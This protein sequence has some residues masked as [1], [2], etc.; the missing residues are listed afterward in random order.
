[1]KDNSQH[2]RHSYLIRLDSERFLKLKKMA[3]D[4]PMSDVVN[5]G[6]DTEWIFY[7]QME[8]LSDKIPNF[9]NID[10]IQDWRMNSF[11]DSPELL[12]KYVLPSTILR[13]MEELSSDRKS[14]QE[15][16]DSL[17]TIQYFIKNIGNNINQLARQANSGETVP[18]RELR[19][20][21]RSII[22]LK[23]SINENFKKEVVK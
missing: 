17:D 21:T 2:N 9:R 4:Q 10:E 18:K 5:R 19:D 8:K 6:I 14:K 16:I 11:H 13:Y 23:N 22:S 20:L 7:C 12:M 3:Q 15:M 1:M